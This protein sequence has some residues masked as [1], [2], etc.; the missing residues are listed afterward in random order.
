MNKE[1]MVYRLNGVLFGHKEELNHI[2][3]RKNG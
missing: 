1:N 2:I 3:F